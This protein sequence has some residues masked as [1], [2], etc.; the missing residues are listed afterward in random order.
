MASFAYTYTTLV[1]LTIDVDI[2]NGQVGEV[3]PL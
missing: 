1:I 3:T 2:Q